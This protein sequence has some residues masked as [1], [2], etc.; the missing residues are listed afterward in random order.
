MYSDKRYTPLYIYII[1]WYLDVQMCILIL[2]QYRLEMIHVY[3]NVYLMF[4]LYMKE[5]FSV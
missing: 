4:H 5:M 1:S 2:L 3:F